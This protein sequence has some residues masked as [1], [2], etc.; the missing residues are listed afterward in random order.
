MPS[1]GL[2][3]KKSV[4]TDSNYKLT[5]SEIESESEDTNQSSGVESVRSR[6]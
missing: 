6:Q 4:G 3:V 2:G 5:A 1:C